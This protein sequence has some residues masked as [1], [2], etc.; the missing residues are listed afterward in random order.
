MTLSSFKIGRNGSF[1]GPWKVHGQGLWPNI[2]HKMNW[3]W[4]H[5]LIFRQVY[6]ELK[7]VIFAFIGKYQRSFAHMSFFL[8]VMGLLILTH[9]I[10]Y[11]YGSNTLNPY[12]QTSGAWGEPDCLKTD[13]VVN[14]GAWHRKNNIKWIL[15]D[16]ITG[17]FI[18]W[19][20]SF[21]V[22][23]SSSWFNI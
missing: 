23:R 9:T 13:P 1:Y 3:S 20:I 15:R 22:K 6:L 14:F 7:S 11:C 5:Y 18:H 10:R 2:R 17:K 21:P 12:W 4:S 19:W 8:V 16:R